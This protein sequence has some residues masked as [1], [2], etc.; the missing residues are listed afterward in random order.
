MPSW[1]AS[2]LR[3]SDHKSKTARKIRTV[4][5]RMTLVDPTPPTDPIDSI[6]SPIVGPNLGPKSHLAT[7]RRPS[8]PTTEL[9][10]CGGA[11]RL[12][13]GGAAA[14]GGIPSVFQPTGR[15]PVANLAGSGVVSTRRPGSHES[16]A[17]L[18]FA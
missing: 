10:S 17:V 12:G 9:V 6:H 13:F 16:V 11:H 2:C 5:S 8:G 1:V 7:V 14:L 3:H 4:R 18:R 15:G